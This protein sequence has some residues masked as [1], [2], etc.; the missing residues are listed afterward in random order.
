MEQRTY[1]H[2]NQTSLLITYFILD[3]SACTVLDVATGDYVPEFFDEKT[4]QFEL[5]VSAGRDANPT[6]PYVQDFNWSYTSTLQMQRSRDMSVLN[7][8]VF[9]G[10]TWECEKS[11][12]RVNAAFAF[13]HH[14]PVT[15]ISL[16]NLGSAL[17]ILFQQLLRTT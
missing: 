15:L 7:M 10:T 2:R 1:A 8:T 3:A 17:C 16:F 6:E 5:P 14:S 4:G 12:R 11:G 13:L 9:A